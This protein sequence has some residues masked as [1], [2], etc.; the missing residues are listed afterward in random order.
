MKAKLDGDTF[1]KL[2]FLDGFLNSNEDR[3]KLISYLKDQNMQIECLVY[4]QPFML[5]PKVNPEEQINI[6][7]PKLKEKK[8]NEQRIQELKERIRILM[9][10]P[11]ELTADLLDHDMFI[12]P[13]EISPEVHTSA[14]VVQLF[15]R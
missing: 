5:E 10:T 6:E 11:L 4:N 9:E 14:R 3:Q 7:N 15:K 8:E 13:Y 2:A 1:D 12:D